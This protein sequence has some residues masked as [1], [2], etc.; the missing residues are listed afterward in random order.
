ML[1][2]IPYIINIFNDLVSSPLFHKGRN[3]ATHKIDSVTFEFH[4]NNK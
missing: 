1:N 3:Y 4:I 2:D